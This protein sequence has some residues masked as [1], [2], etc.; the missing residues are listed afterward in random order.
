MLAAGRVCKAMT[1]RPVERE[2][3]PQIRKNKA[4]NK[5]ASAA[6]TV[7]AEDDDDG[8]NHSSP[9]RMGGN[10][11]RTTHVCA[12]VWLAWCWFVVLL[13]SVLVSAFCGS[14]INCGKPF[15][16]RAFIALKDYCCCFC[17]SVC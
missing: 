7:S 11:L 16:S 9:S 5:A 15:K 2:R 4:L 17:G 10:L 3:Q 8:N 1:L 6:A 14:L 13:V 12:F